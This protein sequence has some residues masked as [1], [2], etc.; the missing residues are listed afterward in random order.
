[1]F[2][3]VPILLNI[4]ASEMERNAKKILPAPLSS[5]L[6]HTSI[7][8]SRIERVADELSNALYSVSVHPIQRIHFRK[9]T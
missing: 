1:M 6:S 9:K 5:P 2:F 3:P 4:D 8:I 7:H